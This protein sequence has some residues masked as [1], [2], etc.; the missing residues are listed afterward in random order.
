M[1]LWISDKPSV[2]HY[3]IWYDLANLSCSLLTLRRDNRVL[4]AWITSKDTLAAKALFHHPDTACNE[5]QLQ[6]I[7]CIPS[8]GEQI[9][10]PAGEDALEKTYRV[11]GFAYHGGGHIVQRVELS[12]DGGKEWK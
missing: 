4:P 9:T 3:H 1:Q 12:I 5:Q 10:I 8:H 2:N 7:T 11:A 6:S